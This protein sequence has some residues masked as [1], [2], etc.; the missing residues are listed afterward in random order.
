M[1][2]LLFSLR[3]QDAGDGDVV[4]IID[5]KESQL[6]SRVGVRSNESLHQA[7]ERAMVRLGEHAARSPV[8]FGEVTGVLRAFLDQG[9]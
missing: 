1:T 6:A 2:E 7:M 3:V 9:D 4:A 8:A 5:W